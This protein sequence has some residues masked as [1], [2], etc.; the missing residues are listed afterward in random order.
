MF[1]TYSFILSTYSS[2]PVHV[3]WDFE[4]SLVNPVVNASLSLQELNIFPSGGKVYRVPQED[5][6]LKSVVGAI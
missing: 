2:S 3:P 4:I 1:F 5:D 6:L